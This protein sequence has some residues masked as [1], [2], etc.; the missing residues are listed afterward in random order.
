MIIERFLKVN[1]NE[2]KFEL[3]HKFYYEKFKAFVAFS[4]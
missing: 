1:R 3:N 4:F 2:N